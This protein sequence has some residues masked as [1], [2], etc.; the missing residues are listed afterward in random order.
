MLAS[1]EHELRR[2]LGWSRRWPETVARIESVQEAIT[3]Y[4][5]EAFPFAQWALDWEALSPAEKERQKAA[6]GEQ[7]R[8]AYMEQQPPTARQIA[9][10]EVLGYRGE[11]TSRQHASQLIGQLKRRSAREQVVS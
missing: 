7:Y 5:A 1:I 9:Y 2:S 3:E 4:R 6:K 8:R 11:I 10:L